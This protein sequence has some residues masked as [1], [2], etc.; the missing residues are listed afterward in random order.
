LFSGIINRIY[1]IYVFICLLN[2][3]CRKISPKNK[4]SSSVLCSC[5]Y[6]YQLR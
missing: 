6:F 3:H 1:Y 4:F 5:R 2:I